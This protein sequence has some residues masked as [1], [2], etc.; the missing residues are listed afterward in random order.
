MQTEALKQCV[1]E[2][3]TFPLGHLTQYHLHKTKISPHSETNRK[4]NNEPIICHCSV[5]NEASLIGQSKHAES[6][7]VHSA[8]S[9]SLYE[10]VMRSVVQ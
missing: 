8:S 3:K 2:Q 10:D 4:G 1:D 7:A 6:L 9:L 5:H